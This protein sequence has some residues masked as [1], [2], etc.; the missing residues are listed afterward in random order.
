M[1]MSDRI[2]LSKDFASELKKLAYVLI[3]LRCFDKEMNP[4]LHDSVH[5]MAKR[6]RVNE[7]VFFLQSLRQHR[8]RIYC[9]CKKRGDELLICFEHPSASSEKSPSV[10]SNV[11]REIIETNN[12]SKIYVYVT[13]FTNNTLQQLVEEFPDVAPHS[14]KTTPRLGLGVRMLFALPPLLQAIEKVKC[15]ADFQLS[16]GREFSLKEV[17]EAAPGTY[18]EWLGH[19]GL[20]AATLYGSIARECFKF[21]RDVYGAEIDH[22]IVSPEPSAAISRIRSKTIIQPTHEPNTARIEESMAYNYRIIEEATGTGFVSGITTDT[23]ALFREEVDDLTS[24]PNARIR[25]EYETIVPVN[26]RNLIEQFFHPG[27][28]HEFSDPATNGTIELTFTQD[29]LMRLEVKFYD[30]LLANKKL[31]EHMTKA[32]GR[33]FT[34]EISL[35]EAYK[36]LTTEKELFFYLAES[37]RMGMKAHLIAP[38]IGF[39]KREDYVESLVELEHRVHKLSVIA[40]HFDAI[41]DFHS[42]SDKRLEVYRTLSKATGGKLKLKMAGIFQLLYFETLASFGLRTVERKLFQRMWKY[43]LDYARRKANEGDETARRMLREARVDTPSAPGLKFKVGPRDEFFRHYSFITVAAKNSLGH[44]IF[45]DELYKIAEKTE[46]AKRYNRRVIKL[47]TQVSK[48][49]GLEDGEIVS[50]HQA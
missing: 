43:T 18:P 23:S 3:Q 34:F 17:V 11:S 9:V 2:P 32:M 8:G 38:N 12:G 33:A 44:Y 40:A 35:D 7:H 45:R 27:L 50:N 15:L 29:E 46:V 16:A 13:P 42:G 37:D 25:V 22:A 20:D 48:A 47:T 24:W 49:L 31:Y 36:S 39:R 4:T 41:L 1:S 26:E 19:T 5:R 28:P 10:V 21:G 6:N 14:M 30:S